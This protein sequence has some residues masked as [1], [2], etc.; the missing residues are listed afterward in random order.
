M[1]DRCDAAVDLHA[2]PTGVA[3]RLIEEVRTLVD[4]CLLGGAAAGHE[5]EVPT[6][7]EGYRVSPEEPMP[8]HI[9]DIYR[10]RGLSWAP[11]SF[12]SQSDANL[13]AANG[14][15]RPVVLGPGQLGLAHTRDES[16]VFA[17]VAQAAGI[18]LELLCKQLQ[19]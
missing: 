3:T 11:G 2:P 14:D 13:M 1:P 17:Q 16:V 9:E 5:V 10:R 12:K 7:F 19:L 18:Y 4:N 6:F 15:C 8:L